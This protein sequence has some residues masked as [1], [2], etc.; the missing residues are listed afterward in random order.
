MKDQI[1]ILSVA[2]AE[3]I[4]REKFDKS[5]DQSDYIDSLVKDFKLN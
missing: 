1:A 2:V 5:S 4:I 3:K